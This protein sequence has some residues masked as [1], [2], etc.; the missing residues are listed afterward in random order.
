MILPKIL[1]LKTGTPEYI[2]Q[3]MALHDMCLPYINSHRAKAIY[4]AAEID[5]RYSVL[6]DADFFSEEPTVETR[7]NLYLQ[8]AQPLAV[9]TIAQAL[10]QAHLSPSDIDHFIV[11][12]CTGIDTPGLDVSVAAEL[13]MRPDLRRS[14]LV[15]MGCYAGVTALD[16]ALLET[17]ARPESRTLILALEFCTLQFQASNKLDDMVAGALFGDGLAATILGEMQNSRLNGPTLLD[18]MTYTHYGTQDMMGVHLSDQGFQIRLAS[19][20]PKLLRQVTPDLVRDFLA[21]SDLT[22]ADVRFWGIHPGGARIVDYVGQ[23]LNLPEDALQ[24]SQRVLRNY[25]NMSSVTIF[26]VMDEIIK[27]GDPK[28][29]DYALL[30]AF[31]PGL[32]I[33][34]CLVQ[35]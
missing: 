1:A 11:T 17:M 6:S 16:R 9:A 26:F 8:A 14:G 27:T 23:A 30:L 13:G 4:K 32:T 21:K 34:L 31:G 2:H 12:S 5:T 10:S 20:V 7:N 24:Y 25:G 3:Q 19:K 29:G 15:G 33:E 18:T 35:W 22:F 28:A